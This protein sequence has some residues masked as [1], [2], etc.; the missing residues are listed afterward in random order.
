MYCNF[1]SVKGKELR[2][3]YVS[4]LLN[5][6]EYRKDFFRNIGVLPQT[7]YFGGGTPSLFPPDK[8][9]LILS[10]LRERFNFT[11]I[12]ATVEVNPNDITLEYA[13]ALRK[14][15]F[16]RVSMGVQSF[17]DS[18][19]AWMNR[20]HRGEEA[21]AAF[22]NLRRAGFSNIS[23]DLIFGYSGLDMEQWRSNIE[24]MVSLAPEHISAYQMSI[25]EGSLLHRRLLKGEYDLVPDNTCM[26]QYTMLQRM[27]A[28]SGYT[29]YEISNFAAKDSGGNLLVSRHNSS[30]WTKEPYLGLGPAAHSYNGTH[31]FWN[32][33]NLT[34][35]C[36]H[37]SS[38]AAG[39]VAASSG[40]RGK[41]V[42]SE[43][44]SAA[45]MFNESIMLGLRRVEGVDISTLNPILLADVMGEIGRHVRLGNLVRE[46][47]KIRI[48]SEKLFVSDGIIMDLFI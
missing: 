31:R 13:M 35:W 47:D 16:N 36:R 29:Q 8:L 12:E 9:E 39:E 26:E 2:E 22:W 38:D 41:I 48:P 21:V 10:A 11:P 42:G 5:E 6:I 3:K 46:G 33:G 23:L 19:L 45:D 30:Y 34:A 17:H 25:E 43:E 32:G 37:Y 7:V 44:L 15:R 4:A 14:A 24:K 27:L 1:Y 18:H 28:Q 20:R 40:R